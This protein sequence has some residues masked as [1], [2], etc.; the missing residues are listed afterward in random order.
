MIKTSYFSKYKEPN[1]ISI[2]L[3]TPTCFTGDRYPDINPTYEMLNEY[4]R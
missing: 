2:A 4:K 1:G 3:S